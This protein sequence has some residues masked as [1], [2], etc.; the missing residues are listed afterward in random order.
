M[1]IVLLILFLTS[2][3][4]YAENPSHRESLVVGVG[5]YSI[6]AGETE[7]EGMVRA[8]AD[9]DSKCNGYSFRISSW[10]DRSAGGGFAYLRNIFATFECK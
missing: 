2:G 7:E 8:Q 6:T 5:S 4:V 1:K 3:S 9:A 10:T